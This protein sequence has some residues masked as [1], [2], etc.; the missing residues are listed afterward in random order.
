MAA[1]AVDAFNKKII[2]YKCDTLPIHLPRDHWPKDDL[3]IA[4]QL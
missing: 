1:V 4:L 3:A 2:I